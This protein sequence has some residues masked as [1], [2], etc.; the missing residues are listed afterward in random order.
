MRRDRGVWHRHSGWAAGLVLLALAAG[1]GQRPADIKREEFISVLTETCRQKY[2]TRVV[3]KEAGDTVWVYLPYMPG[4]QGLAAS[5]RKEDG[6]YVEYAI[7]SLNPFRPKDPPEL[8]F[9]VQ[10][11]LAEI[12][13]AMLRTHPPYEYFVLVVTDVSSGLA[14]QEDWYYGYLPDIKTHK[15]GVDFI[16][17]GYNRLAWYPQPLKAQPDEEGNG[18]SEAYKDVRGDHVDVHEVTLDEFIERQITWRVYRQ[19]T[20]DYGKTAFDMSHQEKE[21]AV[22]RIVRTVFIAYNYK[23]VE[24]VSLRDSSFLDDEK[25]YN[26][27]TR[28]ELGDLGRELLPLRKP[29]F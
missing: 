9:L 25:T 26:T 3:V 13:E 8:R 4:R 10:K 19:F 20:I 28:S 1:C 21:D 14:F 18:V 11:V 7:A 24:K 12:R 5:M 29:G 6:L 23:G 22:L 15:V 27:W 17:E 16:G 2:Q